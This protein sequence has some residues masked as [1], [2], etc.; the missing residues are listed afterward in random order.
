MQLDRAVN[1]ELCTALVS[2]P[3]F[4]LRFLQYGGSVTTNLLHIMK[5]RRV[6]AGPEIQN[7]QLM[8][9]PRSGSRIGIHICSIVFALHY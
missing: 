6:L 3:C 5:S 9:M 8:H 4:V 2:E 7:L 1:S